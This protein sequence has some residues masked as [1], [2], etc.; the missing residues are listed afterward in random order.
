MFVGCEFCVLS[1]RVLCYE[2]ITRPDEP[3]RLWCAVV[4]DLENP[5]MRSHTQSI[6][7]ELKIGDVSLDVSPTCH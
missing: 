6:V 1:G 3:Y 5:R 4:C 7:I 2:L